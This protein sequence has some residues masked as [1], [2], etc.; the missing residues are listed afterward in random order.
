LPVKKIP[1]KKMPVKKMPVK[2]DVPPCPPVPA[3]RERHTNIQHFLTFRT[4]RAVSI[5]KRSCL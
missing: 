4:K 1:V 3:G 5:P 2:K